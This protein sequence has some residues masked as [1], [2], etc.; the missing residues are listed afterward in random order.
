MLFLTLNMTKILAID[1]SSENCSVALFSQ[2]SITSECES[3]PR[4]HT[5][6]ILPMVKS[7]IANQGLALSDLDA[8]AFGCGPGSFTG[9][10]ISAGIAQ[11]LA[12]G[13]NCPVYPVSSLEALALQS[14]RQTGEKR[15]FVAIDARMDEVYWGAY[16]LAVSGS[17]SGLGREVSIINLSG[18]HV[19]A[20]EKVDYSWMSGEGI[21][22]KGVGSGL[23]YLERFPEVLRKSISSFKVDFEPTADAIVE[24]ALNAFLRGDEG[25]ISDALPSY[26][27]DTIT[28]KKLPGR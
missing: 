16:E 12:F 5:Q 8:V 11:G 18:E 25:S 19:C 1:T 6:R 20:P 21:G 3:A 13:L 23:V 4:N 24:L 17:D 26:V 15:V 27:R 7:V 2:N 22:L 10:R 9:I 14:F 28:W